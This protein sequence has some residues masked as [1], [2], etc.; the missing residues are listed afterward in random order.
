MCLCVC[1]C[2]LTIIFTELPKFLSLVYFH[3][4]DMM[5][6]NKAHL[7]ITDNETTTM[8]ISV[9][10]TFLYFRLTHLL[11][12]DTQPDIDTHTHTYRRVR[13]RA[14]THTHTHADT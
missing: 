10:N 12:T 1:L 4:M 14:S 2:V 8:P 7:S 13:R 5:L 9:F 11:N 3:V 6:V